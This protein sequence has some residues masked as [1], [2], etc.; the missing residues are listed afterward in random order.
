MFDPRQRP[1]IPSGLP[2]SI[3]KRVKTV[4][5]QN[6]FLESPQLPSVIR[7][8]RLQERFD[9]LDATIEQTGT[10][11]VNK[12]GIKV[13]NP[14]IKSQLSIQSALVTQERQLAVAIVS[15]GNNLTKK[16]QSTP[17]KLS[18]PTGAPPLRLA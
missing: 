2:P 15:R 10:V 4:L 5:E 16:D 11:V 1:R 8:A 14:L 17:E 9:E 7:Y 12:D 13:P 3:R 6:P 18:R